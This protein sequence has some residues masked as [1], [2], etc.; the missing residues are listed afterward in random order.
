MKQ[1]VRRR[2]HALSIDVEEYFHPNALD[3]WIDPTTWDSLPARVEAN[4]LRVLDLLAA[5]ETRATFFV[6]GWV[7]ERFPALVRAIA[8]RGHEVAC[9]GHAHRLAYRLGPDAFRED[10]R[11]AKT[12]LEDCLGAPVKGFRAASFSI[13]PS[14]P[15]A[16][17]ILIEAGFAYDAS[18]FP[19]RH[20]IYGFPGFP[21]FPVRLHGRAGEITEIPASTVSI[22]GHNWPV[23]GGGY[24]RLLPISLTVRAIERIA[25]RDDAAAIVYVHPWEFDP[26]Q[27]RLVTGFATRLRQYANIGRTEARLRQL[28]QTFEFAPLSDVF[29][30]AAAPRFEPRWH[31]GPE[32]QA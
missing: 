9:H 16:I 25:Q 11:R 24:L 21:R 12:T 14:T 17:D 20:D 27:P 13:V 31:R 2:R 6:L 18:I 23:A 29:D 32:A 1:P 3:A 10:V 26:Q 7:A 19:V 15:W 22:L 30:L 8:A 4:T 28:L 5:R